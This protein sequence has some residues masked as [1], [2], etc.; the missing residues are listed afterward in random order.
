MRIRWNIE[1]FV[2][3][4]L[5]PVVFILGVTVHRD[6]PNLAV[7]LVVLGVVMLVLATLLP[8]LKS[9][10]A[11]VPGFGE[12]SV[13]L[14]PATSAVSDQALADPTGPMADLRGAD[15]YDSRK[16]AFQQ[17]VM[18]G[19]ATYVVINLEEGKSWLTSRLYLFV[20][21]LAEVRGIDAVVF[22]TRVNDAN[23][24]V[25][26]CSVDSVLRRLGWAFPWLPMKLGEAWSQVRLGDGHKPPARRL[27]GHQAAELYSKYVRSLQ[28][29]ATDLVAPPASPSAPAMAPPA[30]GPPYPQMGPAP[31]DPGPPAPAG[32][33]APPQEWQNIGGVWE[34]ANWLDAAF[35]KELMGEALSTQSVNNTDKAELAGALSGSKAK[36]IAVLNDRDEVQSLIDRSKLVAQVMAVRSV[37]TSEL[38]PT[39]RRR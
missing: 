15:P 27:S 3:A 2:L 31:L 38:D 33:P 21:V 16:S 5:G 8:R 32:T 30:V 26:L 7:V 19:P 20:D 12:I 37:P 17:A 22:T 24:F 29:W 35:L 11:N 14:L 28:L 10:S 13:D 18:G 6:R 1:Q 4:L 36:Y 25:G 34:H 39:R 9:L 23:A